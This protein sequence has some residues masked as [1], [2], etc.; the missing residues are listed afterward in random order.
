[1]VPTPSDP[2]A[3]LPGKR[4]RTPLTARERF[5]SQMQLI[6]EHTGNRRLG[7]QHYR[8]D[9]PILTSELAAFADIDP[10]RGEVRPLSWVGFG[11]TPALHLDAR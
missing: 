8:C 1:M 10:Y 7:L 11:D 4:S 2:L 6:A 9:W 3:I 5:G